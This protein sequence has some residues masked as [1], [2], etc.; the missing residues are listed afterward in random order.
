M[1]PVLEQF[2]LSAALLWLG[3]EMRRRGLTVEVDVPREAPP[4][5][6]DQAALL[7]QS[8]RELL[9]NVM[10]HSQTTQAAVTV[11]FGDEQPLVVTVTDRG[12]GFDPAVAQVARDKF[13][14]F[15][16]RERMQ[17]LAAPSPSNRPR[18]RV[19]WRRS[20]SRCAARQH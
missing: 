9:M 6:I 7:Y 14:L 17:A 3:E 2:G 5:S 4:L 10:K 18:G 8:T 12:A 19:L 15:S 1:P 11:T 20:R 13:G 16:I